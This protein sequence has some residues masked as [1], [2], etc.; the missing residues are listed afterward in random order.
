[1]SRASEAPGQEEMG[2]T[3]ALGRSDQ[4]DA[5]VSCREKA[6]GAQARCRTFCRCDTTANTHTGPGRLATVSTVLTH[7]GPST[8][9]KRERTSRFRAAEAKDTKENLHTRP[10]SEASAGYNRESMIPAR[11]RGPSHRCC[12]IQMRWM[13]G[14]ETR[15]LELH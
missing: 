13:H 11:P 12:G 4:F 5:D 8:R 10:E 15:R 3:A 1:M 9:F 14:T 2:L 6:R 7:S